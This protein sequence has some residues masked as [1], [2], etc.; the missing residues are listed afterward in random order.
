M[1]VW[2]KYLVSAKT[3]GYD[4]DYAYIPELQIPHFMEAN[5]DPRIPTCMPA[6]VITYPNHWERVSRP[7]DEWMW[8]RG[9][10]LE[11]R[12]KDLATHLD[13]VRETIKRESRFFIHRS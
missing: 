11:R 7:S 4:F 2:V 6:G 5:P 1:Y 8:E 9:A 10:Y 3:G 12:E 13:R